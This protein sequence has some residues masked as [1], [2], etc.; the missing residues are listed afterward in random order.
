MLGFLCSNILEKK[1][2][3]CFY[4]LL[5]ILIMILLAMLTKISLYFVKGDNKIIIINN[6]KNIKTGV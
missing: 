2:W 6:N 1:I 3:I 4:E 5:N